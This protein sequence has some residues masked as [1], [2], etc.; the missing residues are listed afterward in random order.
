MSGSDPV[1]P[2]LEPLWDSV[3]EKNEEEKW[4]ELTVG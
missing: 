3:E 4:V 2:G 1:V